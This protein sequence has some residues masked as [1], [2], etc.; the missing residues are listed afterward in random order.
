[1]DSR[2]RYYTQCQNRE[3]YRRFVVGIKEKEY[4]MYLKSLLF[5]RER[6][7]A[8]FEKVHEIY[9]KTAKYLQNFPFEKYPYPGYEA[10][11]FMCKKYNFS[12]VLDIGCGEGLQSRAFLEKG[13]Q[14]TAIDYGKSNRVSSFEHNPN[15]NLIIDD[16]NTY[17]FDKQYDCVWSSHVLEHQLDPHQ[18]LCKMLSLVREGGVV[19]ITVP[20]YKSEI[21]GGH[22]NLWNAGLL[23]YR[24][25]LAGCD[26]SEAS[27]KK[28]GYNVSVVT[29]KKSI[30]PLKD[31]RYDVGD[32]QI[33][34][35]Y[36]PKEIKF[37]KEFLGRDILF[38]GNIRELNWK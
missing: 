31:I 23:L 35:R 10:L 7:T 19:A 33:L 34:E 8:T 6:T 26:C 20:P 32:L 5:E 37:E 18:F 13:K 16:F 24:L 9:Q 30:Q 21:I 14:V 17:I 38:E 27:V 28:Y 3:K 1:M 15:F 29:T 36:F 12:T 4:D 2:K 22:V 11:E 25:V